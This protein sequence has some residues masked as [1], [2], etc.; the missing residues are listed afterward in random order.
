MGRLS[1]LPVIYDRLKSIS[2]ADLKKWNL[3]KSSFP[4]QGQ[5]TWIQ[6]DRVNFSINYKLGF[7]PNNYLILNYHFDG[8]DYNYSVR[9]AHFPSNLG[10]GMV[11]YF[12]CPVTGRT[13]RKLHLNNGIFQHRGNIDGFYQWQIYSHKDRALCRIYDD[14]K[15]C[16]NAEFSMQEKYFKKFYLN[17]PTKRYK[18]ILGQISKGD[19]YNNS[20]IESL[21]AGINIKSQN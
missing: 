16:H 20:A 1:G 19:R 7:R 2:T 6:N 12:V 3:L 4:R 8:R 17:H 14:I 5:I 13:C 15:I 18:K 21:M 11:N 9:I 10:K